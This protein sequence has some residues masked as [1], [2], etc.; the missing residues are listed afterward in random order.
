MSNRSGGGGSV[1]LRKPRAYAEVYNDLDGEIVNLFRVARDDGEALAR[2]I[3]LTPFARSEFEIGYVPADDPLEQARRTLSRSYMGFGSAGAS[4][5]ST[6]FRANSNRSGTTS[7]REWLNYPD[8]LRVTIQRLRGVVIENRDAVDVMHAHDCE[9]AVHYVD[10]P[11]VHSTRQLRTRA[12]IYR[13]ELTDAQHEQLGLVLAGLRGM[14]V[15]SGYRCALYDSLFTGWQRIDAAAHADGARDRIESLWLSP[16][17]PA[18]DL[19]E[20]EA[21]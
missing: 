1:L 21:A 14:V 12:P 6:G 9:Q 17:C 5:Q 16:N 20:R 19:F 4:G 8:C 11:Y 3:E 7:A 13:H 15:V 2:A 18:A 10:P